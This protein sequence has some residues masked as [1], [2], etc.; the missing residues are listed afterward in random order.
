VPGHNIKALFSKLSKADKKRITKLFDKCVPELPG[1]EVVLSKGIKMD[2]DSVL[3]RLSNMFETSRYWQDN[4]SAIVGGFGMGRNG[5]ARGSVRERATAAPPRH[6][7][8]SVHRRKLVR[9]CFGM[10][11]RPQLYW[12]VLVQNAKASYQPVKCL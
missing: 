3:T 2:I 9:F 8:I 7:A 4:P 1:V 5:P 6:P 11:F 12:G 10:R